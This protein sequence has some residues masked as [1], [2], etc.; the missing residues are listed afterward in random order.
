MTLVL[1]RKFISLIA[2]ASILITG[3]AAAPAR[4]GDDDVARALAALVGIAII[5]AAINDARKDDHAQP[6]VRHKPRVAPRPL[7]RRVNRKL[8]PQRCFRSFWGDRGGQVRGFGPKCLRNNYPFVRSLPQ[9]CLRAVRG[10]GGRHNIYGAR[11]L[12]S[13]GYQ[14]ARH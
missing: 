4:A 8:L 1:H 2:G 14:L 12:R 6:V 3:L 11:C 5:G 7:P 10:S 13:K 9:T